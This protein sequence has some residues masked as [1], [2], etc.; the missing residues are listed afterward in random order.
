MISGSNVFSPREVCRFGAH[1][2]IDVLGFGLRS[3]LEDYGDQ[4]ESWSARC[5]IRVLLLDPEFPS[6]RT[7]Y[8]DQ[9][10]REEN[11]QQ[12]DIGRDVREFVRRTATLAERPGT[13]FQVRLFRCLPSVNI[14]RIDDKL[15]WGPYLVGSQSRNMPTFVVKKG[16]HLYDVLGKHF[17][18][19]WSRDDLSRPVPDAWR[20]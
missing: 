20:R 5:T 13:R 3:L 8:A 14:F 17:E 9:R 4:F 6:A 16:G 2:S 12:G 1:D 11:N 7:P 10:D 19:I 18:S 15:F